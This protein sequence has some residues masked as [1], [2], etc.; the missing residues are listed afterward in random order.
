MHAQTVSYSGK[1]KCVRARYAD[2]A[3]LA[4]SVAKSKWAQSYANHTDTKWA[5]G[6][7]EEFQRDAVGYANNYSQMAERLMDKFTNVAMETVG[8]DL[9]YNTT[10]GMLDYEAMM[11]GEPD[12][13]FG[14]TDTETESGPIK[15]YMDQWI[16]STIPA[17][18]IVRRGVACLALMQAIMVHRPVMLEV[19]LA[20]RHGRAGVDVIQ[21]VPAPTNPLNLSLASWMVASPCF[22]RRGYMAMTY[23]HANTMQQDGIPPLGAGMAWQSSK[24]GNFLAEEDGIEDFVFLPMMIDN[25][26]AR[27]KSDE[28][29]ILWIKREL[30]RLLG[31][32]YRGD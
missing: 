31:S 22:V 11:A 19:V 26:D 9:E 25:S 15:I 6:T 4:D 30:K 18:T 10:N 20:N 28:N 32:K 2:M 29:T 27:W 5:G 1:N 16:S 12:C 23:H 8:L 7:Y 13:L 17:S 24:L 21:T 3:D 14:M